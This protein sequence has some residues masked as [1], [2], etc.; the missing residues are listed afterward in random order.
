M[1][2]SSLTYTV[3]EVS[4]DHCVEA[5]TEEVRQVERVEAV[6]VDLAAKHVTV[7]GERLD[8]Q[9]VCKAIADA[10]YDVAA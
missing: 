2:Q 1:S 9:A 4:C 6:D 5:I 10:G 8:G 3:P 7:T